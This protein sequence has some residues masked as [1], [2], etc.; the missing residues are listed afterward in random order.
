MLLGVHGIRS[1]EIGLLFQ[2]M[3]VDRRHPEN[4]LLDT[5]D[6]KRSSVEEQPGYGVD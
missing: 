2:F 1:H 4:G 5:V 3:A 6:T